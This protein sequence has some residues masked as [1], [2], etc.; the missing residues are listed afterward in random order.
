[1]VLPK[2][3]RRDEVAFVFQSLGRNLK[4]WNYH[5]HSNAAA[6]D[7]VHH[8]FTRML[9]GLLISSSPKLEISPQK[10]DY[11]SLAEI[12]NVV[13]SVPVYVALEHQIRMVRRK[14][15]CFRPMTHSKL[16]ARL[17]VMLY[18]FMQGMDLYIIHYAALVPQLQDVFR[19]TSESALYQNLRPSLGMQQR[20]IEAENPGLREIKMAT[21][22]Y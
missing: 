7:T 4:C 8:P 22:T 5:L 21:P 9:A 17:S 20:G 12:C 1:M 14:V 13:P 19:N 3:K 11:A 16:N 18:V 15:T 10:A 6:D 2:T